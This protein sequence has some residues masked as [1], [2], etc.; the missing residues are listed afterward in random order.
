MKSAEL[1]RNKPQKKDISGRQLMNESHLEADQKHLSSPSQ[2]RSSLRS[3]EQIRSGLAKG[4]YQVVFSDSKTSDSSSE[5]DVIQ[6][7]GIY[8]LSQEIS[9][10]K[11]LNLNDTN[12]VDSYKLPRETRLSNFDNFDHVSLTSTPQHKEFL[13]KLQNDK[14]SRGHKDYSGRLAN[15]MKTSS[16]TSSGGM[17][18]PHTETGNNSRSP[19]KISSDLNISTHLSHNSA[20]LD[21]HFSTLS[22]SFSDT[23]SKL[24]SLSADML[25]ENSQPVTMRPT[26]LSSVPGEVKEPAASRSSSSSRVEYKQSESLHS[27]TSPKHCFKD[28]HK[29]ER[30][31][32]EQSSTVSVLHSLLTPTPSI[33]DRQSFSS[34]LSNG[35]GVTESHSPT[36]PEKT[37][38]V[39]AVLQQLLELVD[40]HWNGSGS[41]LFNKDFLVP[42]QNLL[43]HLVACTTSQHAVHLPAGHSS[44]ALARND[45]K[46]QRTQ[47]KYTEQF[48][49]TNT[50]TL[51]KGLEE[52]QMSASKLQDMDQTAASNYHIRRNQA[53]TYDDLLWKNKQLSF[54]VEFLRL[55]L[56]Q[57]NRLQETVA[58]LQDSQRSLL[59]ANNFLMQQL[60]KEN[61]PT[62]HK[63]PLPSERCTSR[64]RSPPLERT[65]PVPS[66]YS[67]GQYCSSE[68]LYNCL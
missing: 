19:F 39:T 54:Q 57:L 65:A 46:V 36:R 40:C 16:Q 68:K 9:S 53:P 66:A 48:D 10:V 15:E 22:A 49:R 25:L 45:S 62:V 23:T 31:C 1:A 8:E 32:D 26:M 35:T 43:L 4:G 14:S 5:R 38:H 44:S 13:K 11:R 20:L 37:S 21:N 61:S 42:A 24:H 67:S 47:L 27:L 63:T 52:S 2:L 34:E 64:E 55:E 33:T 30:N 41:L 51:V 58:L 18:T 6:K 12:T 28:S 59:A 29:E 3:P 60:N 56:K 50:A 7:S 17:L